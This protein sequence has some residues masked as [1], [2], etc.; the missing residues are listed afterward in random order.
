MVLGQSGIK[1]IS[2]KLNEIVNYVPKNRFTS[3]VIVTGIILFI[4][5]IYSKLK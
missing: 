4:I 1:S 5:V 3:I 2:S